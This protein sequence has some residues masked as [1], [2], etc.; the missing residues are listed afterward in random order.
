[1][2]LRALEMGLEKWSDIYPRHVLELSENCP[3]RIRSRTVENTDSIKSA[4]LKPLKTAD[5]LG[6]SQNG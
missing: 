3:K 5:F 1:M 4:R 6:I 2:Q